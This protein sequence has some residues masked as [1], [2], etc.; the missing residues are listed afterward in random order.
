MSARRLHAYVLLL[1][2]AVIWGIAASVIKFTEQGISALP[3]LTYRFGISAAIAGGFFAI[4]RTKLPKNPMDILH[5][6][7]Y[8]VLVSTIALGLLFLGLEH[9]SVIEMNL[10]T[11]TAPLITSIIGV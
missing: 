5:L 4:T 2:V 11:A 3:F 9:T 10:I 8:G 7:V 1:I 6:V